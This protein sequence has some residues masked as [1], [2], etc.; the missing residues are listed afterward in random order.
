[1]ESRERPT[2]PGT[3]KVVSNT[4]AQQITETLCASLVSFE[5]TKPDG[6]YL[7][8]LE[9]PDIGAFSVTV[10]K[11]VTLADQTLGYI[12]IALVYLSVIVMGSEVKLGQLQHLMQRP[13]CVGAAQI[14]NMIIQPFMAFLLSKLFNLSPAE[15]L[16]LVMVG[17]CP[18]GANSNMF[19]LV[20]HGEITL[21][22]VVTFMS[23]FMCMG[24]MPLNL[25]TYSNFIA[26]D[27]GVKSVND[28]NVP[29]GRMV[30]NMVKLLIPIL[31]GM[32]LRYFFPS[33]DREWFRRFRWIVAASL[34]VSSLHH[35]YS[36]RFVIQLINSKLLGVAC[37]LPLSGF[38]TGAIL[39]L[40]SRQRSSAIRTVLLGT[41]LQDTFLV[42]LIVRDLKKPPASDL[43]C[44]IPHICASFALLYAFLCYAAHHLLLG[45]D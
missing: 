43:D 37:L 1:M 35:I 5:F 32:L 14:T 9:R 3:S 21:S 44:A 26:G 15:S 18:A 40:I 13:G 25:F 45:S 8:P 2:V 34:F 30:I 16:Y 22:F 12:S 38:L 31:C 11:R 23:T 24:W 39:T 29:Y 27:T 4:Y 41:G 20:S 19:C 42:V 7:Q 6:S 28:V 36:T 10:V 17:C 33:T